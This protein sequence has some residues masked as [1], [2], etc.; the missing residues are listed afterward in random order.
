[1]ESEVI[2]ILKRKV[3]AV[4]APDRVLIFLLSGLGDTLMFSPAL[5]H[6]RLAWP[7]TRMVAL[8]M[9]P[10]EYDVLHTNRDLDEVLMWPSQTP[11]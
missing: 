8:T 2:E 6:L 9:R 7:R 10:A 1:M 4:K 5:R 3:Q 11:R